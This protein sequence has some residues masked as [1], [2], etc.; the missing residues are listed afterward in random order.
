MAGYI[1][2]ED[3]FVYQISLE[4]CD[5]AWEIYKPLDW[6]DKKTMGDQFIT[7]V[8]SNAANI[9]EGYGRYHYLDKVKFYINARASLMESKHWATVMHKRGLITDEQFKLFISKNENVHFHLNDYIN[10]T[11][12]QKEVSS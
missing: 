1:K 7:A 9:V 4:L 12:R 8:D 2:I 6:R 5:L 10:I 3:I 11:R